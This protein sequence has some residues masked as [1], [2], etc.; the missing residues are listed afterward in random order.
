MIFYHACCHTSFTN[1]VID[2]ESLFRH[3]WLHHITDDPPSKKPLPTE[4][5]GLQHEENLSIFED[6]KYIP[7]STTRPKVTGWVPGQKK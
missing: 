1:N 7:Y 4:K 5:W 2:L 6:K 3:R